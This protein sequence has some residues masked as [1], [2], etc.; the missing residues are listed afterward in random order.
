MPAV[1]LI[2]FLGG[3]LLLVVG[4]ISPR[5]VRMRRHTT[6]KVGVGLLLIG[7]IGFVVTVPKPEREAAVSEE[8]AQRAASVPITLQAPEA[9]PVLVWRD[10]AAMREGW[11]LVQAGVHETNPQMVQRLLACVA[12]SGSPIIVTDGGLA[13]STILVIGGSALDCRGDVDNINVSRPP[14]VRR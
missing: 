8:A 13:T 2:V 14:P 7:S 5:T 6:G 9:R 11:R 10:G 1:M 12:P 4:L 3:L